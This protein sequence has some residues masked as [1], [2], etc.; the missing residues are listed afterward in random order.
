MSARFAATAFVFFLFMMT[1]PVACAQD[2]GAESRS[3]ESGPGLEAMIGQMM[4]VGFRGFEA[5]ESHWVV[6][7]IRD[8][9]LGG[10]ILFDYDVPNRRAERNVRSPQQLARLVRQLPRT[11]R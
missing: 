8:R 7:D 5:D 11:L 1:A 10:I 2:S 4:M 9:N 6:Q 3:E